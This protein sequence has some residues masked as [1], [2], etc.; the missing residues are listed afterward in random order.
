MGNNVSSYPSATLTGIGLAPP[1]MYASRYNY[2]LMAMY[3]D[4]QTKLLMG[5]GMALMA[6]ELSGF[7]AAGLVE[8]GLSEGVVA[9]IMEAVN[10]S[11]GG[12]VTA[13]EEMVAKGLTY[14]GVDVNAYNIKRVFDFI[15]SVN[16]AWDQY[17]ED[18]NM[19]KEWVSQSFKDYSMY[20]GNYHP[21]MEGVWNQ[22]TIEDYEQAYNECYMFGNCEKFSKLLSER[23]I[24]DGDQLIHIQPP[25][26]KYYVDS[27]GY[28][29]E[30]FLTKNIQ[31]VHDQTF[32]KGPSIEINETPT[33]GTK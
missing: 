20:L 9:S 24:Y 12:L 17:V 6:P 11:E 23:T 31:V 21:E 27:S 8:L 5:V 10:I 4:P 30:Q 1:F 26:A 22:T 2:D 19:D 18:K 14:V 25:E 7:V 3:N 28:P 16:Q 15:K 13:T 33:T 29:Q 32:D